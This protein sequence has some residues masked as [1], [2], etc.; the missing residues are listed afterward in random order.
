MIELKI[1]GN[2][3][4]ICKRGKHKEIFGDYLNAMLTIIESFSCDTGIQRGDCL[5]FLYQS[6]R[7]IYDDENG[8]E[9][10]EV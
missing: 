3:A 2:N 8:V 5:E 7:E 6:I 1:N 4:T 10:K 9:F